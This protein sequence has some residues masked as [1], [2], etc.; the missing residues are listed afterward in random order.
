[1]FSPSGDQVW[2]L[3]AARRAPGC[4]E[5]DDDGPAAEP[6]ETDATTVESLEIEPH[7][8]LPDTRAIFLRLGRNGGY[9]DEERHGRGLH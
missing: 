3:H 6:G 2:H 1:V 7:G 8:Y 4:P 9:R 5:V